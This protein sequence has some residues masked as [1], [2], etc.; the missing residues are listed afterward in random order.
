MCNRLV[1]KVCIQV[2]WPLRSELISAFIAKAHNNH[3]S[4]GEGRTEGVYGTVN[5]R[6]KIEDRAYKNFVF[7]IHENKQ[8]RYSF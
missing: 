7:P 1:D 4:Y 5:E 6:Q 3:N 2:K 8:V